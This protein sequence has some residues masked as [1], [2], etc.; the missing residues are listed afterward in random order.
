MTKVEPKYPGLP[1]LWSKMPY[2]ML[3]YDCQTTAKYFWKDYREFN[4]LLENRDS[5]Y[6]Q[7]K[8]PKNSGGMRCL[9][10][11]SWIIT[12]HQHYILKNILY[13][14][15]VSEYACAY[16]KRRGLKDL[17][18]PH[19]GNRV[20]I[21]FDLDNFFTNITEQMVFDCLL[22]ETGYPRN[23]VGFLSRLCCYKGYL[24]QGACTS[25]ALSNICFKR[26]DEEIYALAKQYGLRYTRYSDD[27]Y[28]SGEN[29]PIQQIKEAV[30]EILRSN[31]F[32]INNNK[33]KVL[34][35][36]QAQKVTAITVNEKMQ[37]NRAY[38]RQL[39]ME[40]Y[41]LNRFGSNAKDALENGYAEYLYRLL[42]RVSF[43][44]YVDP[45]NQEF[46][47]AKKKLE[48]MLREY[49]T[50]CLPVSGC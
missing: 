11:P 38:R 14:I 21:H 34:Y 17:A 13:R 33:T 49:E 15:P 23:V 25:P 7:I 3:L 5:A 8:I 44:L 47:T 31:G 22:T 41:Y 6:R 18:A 40:L 29:P 2:L 27:I 20:L 10:V 19:I 42:G 24:P 48:R 46:S 9:L 35:P 30:Q 39:R 50:Q 28:L 36:H 4:E 16:H 1:P 26:C 37:V 12:K 45:E 32:K 43:V